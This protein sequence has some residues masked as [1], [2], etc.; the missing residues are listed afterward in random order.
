MLGR[1][2]RNIPKFSRE[3]RNIPKFGRDV[4][5]TPLFRRESQDIN[6]APRPGTELPKTVNYISFSLKKL[7]SEFAFI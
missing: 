4:R 6:R 2:K 5:N 1:D 7:L 3:S